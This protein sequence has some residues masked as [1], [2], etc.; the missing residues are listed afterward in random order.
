MTG[1]FG[2]NAHPTIDE[3]N[4]HTDEELLSPEFR[5]GV[6]RLKLAIRRAA[7]AQGA[8][9]AGTLWLA[10]HEIAVEFLED[11]KGQEQ[12]EMYWSKIQE[13]SAWQFLQPLA[14]AKEE[15]RSGSEKEQPGNSG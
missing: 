1:K 5:K 9:D 13:F 10:L 6:D 8:L 4:T 14:E 15:P 3:T 2:A 11:S 7:V 12:A